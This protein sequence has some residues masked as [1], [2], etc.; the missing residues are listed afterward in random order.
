MEDHSSSAHISLKYIQRL[1]VQLPE[2]A[3]ESAELIGCF[4]L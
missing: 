2:S 1:I 4:G 3:A